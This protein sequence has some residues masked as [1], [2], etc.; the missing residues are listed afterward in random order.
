MSEKT[1]DKLTIR[2]ALPAAIFLLVVVLVVPF[3]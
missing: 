1:W 3:F 2:V